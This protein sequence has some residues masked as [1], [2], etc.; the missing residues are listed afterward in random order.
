MRSKVKF[1]KLTSITVHRLAQKFTSTGVN[2][3][4]HESRK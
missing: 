4:K 3:A 1:E 2:K